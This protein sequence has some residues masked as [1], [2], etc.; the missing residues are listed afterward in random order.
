MKRRG[1]AGRPRAM[2]TLWLALVGVLVAACSPGSAQSEPVHDSPSTAPPPTIIPSQSGPVRD[3]ADGQV[4]A[5][6]ERDGVRLTIE[7]EQNPLSTRTPAWATMTAENLG[8][9]NVIYGVGGCGLMAEVSGRIL[10]DWTG[11]VPQFGAAGAFK[12]LALTSEKTAGSPYLTVGLVPESL[13]D[14]ENVGCA[15]LLQLE[16]LAPGA[17]EVRRALWRGDGT[18]LIPTDTLKL[19]AR[20]PFFRREGEAPDREGP[21]LEVALPVRVRDA[22]PSPLIGP[23]RAIDTA[24]L[25]EE[26]VQFVATYPQAQ[27][28][29]PYLELDAE[30]A[31]WTVGLFVDR[32]PP[33]YEQFGSV[34]VAAISGLAL[35]VKFDPPLP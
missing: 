5:Y 31:I 7:I 20:F 23:G 35:G 1:I 16:S 17:L 26:F 14:K 28:I 30:H 34:R 32:G 29:N 18:D 9:D 22:S 3:A 24:L 21:P 19:V 10:G 12:A 2:R 4:S 6:V 33:D 11:G 15:D 25:Q 13:V 27:W 8:T